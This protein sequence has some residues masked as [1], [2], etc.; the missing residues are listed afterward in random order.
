MADIDGD[1]IFPELSPGAIILHYK[2]VQRLGHGALGE[3]YLADDFRLERRVAL[4]FLPTY[5]DETRQSLVDEA[6]AASKLAHPNIA[7]IY[8]L[9][10]HGG[11]DFIV[12]EYVDGVTLDDY[13]GRRPPLD[14]ILRVAIQI[15]AGLAEA[16]RHGIVHGDLKPQNIMID[17]IG[18]A[19]ICDF[20][21]A[22]LPGKGRP[23]QGTSPDGTL[24]YMSP[25]Q[26][27][28]QKTDVRSDLFSL[29]TVL[30]E[31]FSG[32]RPFH[33]QYEAAIV[34]AI[35]NETPTPLESSRPDLPPG[36]VR[37]ITRLL[38][39]D[40][41]NR[42][43]D[44]EEVAVDLKG[45]LGPTAED[46]T[47]RLTKYRLAAVAALLIALVATVWFFVIPSFIP[48]GDKASQKAMIAVLPFENLGS[49]QYDYW[50][51]GVEDAI[52]TSLAKISGL[53]VISRTSTRQYKNSNKPMKQIGKELGI[54]YAI[55][56]TVLLSPAGGGDSI[57]VNVQLIRVADDTHVWAETFDRAVENIFAIHSEI[58]GNVSRELDIKLLSAEEHSLRARPTGNAAA[59]DYY[60]RGLYYYGR[61]WQRRDVE[62]A[63]ENFEGAVREDSTFAL[64]FA[65]L[66]RA[67]SQ[68]FWDYYDRTD[69]R[70]KKSREAVEAALV[71]N[72]KLPEA[73]LAIGMYYYS[74]FQF[75]EA[76][77]EFKIAE[78]R[79]PG[80]SD[81]SGAIAGVLRRQGKFDEALVYFS[82]A[83]R[84]DPRSQIRA[85][86]VGLTMSMLRRYEAADS[87]LDQTITLSPDWPLPY[88]YKA[89][90]HIFWRGDKNGARN[91]IDEASRITDLSKTE[92]YRYY[93][94]L[95]SIIDTDYNQTLKKIVL[96]PDSA[97]YY[98]SKAKIYQR[99]TKTTV[100]QAYFDSARAVSGRLVASQPGDPSFHSQLGLACA[101]LGLKGEAIAAG[102]KA[103]ELLPYEMDAYNAQFMAANLA[104]IYV[105]V[106]EYDPA[107]D[108]LKELLKRPGFASAA[109]I[110][111]DP[112]WAPLWTNRRFPEI[113]RASR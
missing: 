73:H 1:H 69:A 14:E 97:V 11:H 62:M 31:M 55:E 34:Y 16:H 18:R 94:W 107:I 90:N 40:P 64:A 95:A 44:A 101:G 22:R 85:F 45:V 9:E 2:I 60:L 108:L 76:L 24:S 39:K 68:M 57:R 5:T 78:Q 7:S 30:Y 106:G 33:G 37:I 66:S 89:W 105:L 43:G 91:I 54:G 70:L 29:G 86:D 17:K 100:G 92:Y 84:L 113:D 61:S 59:Y 12:M 8:S 35:V 19:K 81:L 6:R 32:Q 58:A 80:N 112:I 26:A 36:I 4:K 51:D 77:G 79:G 104:E 52:T 63:I 3:V 10:E 41:D 99:A 15:C 53:G 27:Q 42:Y 65:L 74:T 21:L 13:M 50:A 56:G 28:C 46:P 110:R 71:L 67:H 88:I 83:Y 98:L 87:L 72:P 47:S 38:E 96:G 23:R 20:G 111:S 102:K 93:W 25:E 48:A 103:M 82:R 49:T 75:D 109:Y